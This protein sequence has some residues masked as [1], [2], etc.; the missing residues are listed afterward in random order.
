MSNDS[1]KTLKDTAKQTIS[2]LLRKHGFHLDEISSHFIKESKSNNKFQV[3]I[4]VD[5]NLQSPN[6]HENIV[7]THVTVTSKHDASTPATDRIMKHEAQFSHEELLKDGKEIN[8][9]EKVIENSIQQ[10]EKYICNIVL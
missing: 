2:S 7:K 1:G 4:S 5:Y 10:Q 3:S 8:T 6:S 9:I